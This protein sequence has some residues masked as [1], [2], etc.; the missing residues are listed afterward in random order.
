MKVAMGKKAR[1]KGSARGRKSHK[2]KG[3]EK[4]ASDKTKIYRKQF[5]RFSPEFSTSL[6]FPNSAEANRSNL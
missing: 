1:C 5:F 4:A 2:S 6:F 3:L